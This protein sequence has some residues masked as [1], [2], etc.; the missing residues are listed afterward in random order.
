MQLQVENTDEEE[1]I[2]DP[3]DNEDYGTHK[4]DPGAAFFHITF[5]R[6]VFSFFCRLLNTPK[7]QVERPPPLMLSSTLIIDS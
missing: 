6:T 3:A 2:Q 5:C 7:R 4:I 1:Y